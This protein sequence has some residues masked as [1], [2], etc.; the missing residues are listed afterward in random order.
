MNNEEIIIKKLIDIDEKLGNVVT[1]DE[2]GDFKDF[3]TTQ[4]DRQGVILQRV[5]LE[6]KAAH[7][8]LGRVEDRL[9]GIEEHLAGVTEQ[10]GGL[11][12]RFD[13]HLRENGD[14]PRLA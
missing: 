12:D 11:N 5:D 7:T 8:R 10:L 4:F 3:V 13:T 2:F 1:R 14:R 6:V 9:D